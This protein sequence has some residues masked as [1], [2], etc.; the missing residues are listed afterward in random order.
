MKIAVIGLGKIGLPL[1]AQFADAGHEVIGVDI[2]ADT[3]ETIN[4]GRAP[5]PGEDHLDDYL[6]RLVPAG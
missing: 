4:A 3:V 6:A 1:A 5:F 2:N